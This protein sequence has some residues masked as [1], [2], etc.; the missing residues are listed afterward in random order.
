MLVVGGGRARCVM[1]VSGAV[2]S[3]VHV[4]TAGV[5]STLPAASFARTRNVCAARGEARV[6]SAASVHAAH[7]RA[8]ELALEGQACRRR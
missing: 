6:G 8:V 7:G 1:T 3:I 5:G 2:R 4:W